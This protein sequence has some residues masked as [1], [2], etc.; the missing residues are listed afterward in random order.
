MRFRFS[1][2]GETQIDRTLTR[3]ADNIDDARPLW[4]KLADRFATAEARQFDSEGAY[5][6]GGWPALSSAYA[7]W[8]AIHYPGKRILERTGA[9]RQGLASRPFGVEV[10]TERSLTVGSGLD[11]GR[12]HQAGGGSLPQ[13][14]PVELPESE[15]REWVKLIGNYVRTG[16]A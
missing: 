11:Y 13:R 9:L 7:A 3:W 1:V 14:R 4:D 8:K 12:Y 6:S 2:E 5:G 15:R 10:I 16:R